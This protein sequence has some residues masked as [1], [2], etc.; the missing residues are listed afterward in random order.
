[1]QQITFH[2]E[3][4]WDRLNFF[5]EYDSVAE[6]VSRRLIGTA[7]TEGHPAKPTRF[8]DFESAPRGPRGEGEGETRDRRVPVDSPLAEASGAEIC[9]ASPSRKRPVGPRSIPRRPRRAARRSAL[10]VRRENGPSVEKNTLILCYIVIHKSFVNAE[11]SARGSAVPPIVSASEWDPFVSDIGPST[12]VF[13]AL[14]PRV[15]VPGLR[16][17]YPRAHAPGVVRRRRAERP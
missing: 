5:S 4:V 8:F 14:S 13:R 12:F 1:M 2:W 15:K 16:W 17:A 3:N 9:L 6:R 11:S 10:R 7:D